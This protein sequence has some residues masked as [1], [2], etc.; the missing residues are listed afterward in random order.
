MSPRRA[1]VATLT[2]LLLVGIM[3]FLWPRHEITEKESSRGPARAASAGGFAA[4]KKIAPPIATETSHLA[5]QLNSPKGNITA[6]LH[7]VGDV[8]ENFRS[9]FPRDGNPVGSNAEITAAL[10]GKNKLGYAVIPPDHAAINRNGEL[11][12]RWGT[13]FF[14]HAESGRHM[15]IRSAGPDKKMWTADDEEFTP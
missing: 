3:W 7:I 8:L 5:D 12:D 14:F 13:P 10:T 6:D 9:N 2:A 15:S 11:C 1:I 4:D